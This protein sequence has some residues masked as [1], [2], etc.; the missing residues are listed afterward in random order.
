MTLPIRAEELAAIAA[1]RKVTRCPTAFVVP[2]HQAPSI[3][4]KDILALRKHPEPKL[5]RRWNGGR[6]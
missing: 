4:R 3:S 5:A 1:F 6:L 2:M